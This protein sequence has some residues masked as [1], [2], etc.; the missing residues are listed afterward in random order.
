LLDAQQ[1]QI[2]TVEAH[3]IG[4]M[5]MMVSAAI[6]RDSTALARLITTDTKVLDPSTLQQ[7]PVNPTGDRRPTELGYFEIVTGGLSDRL[8]EYHTYYAF[9]DESLA[10]VYAIGQHSGLQTSW[11]HTS[12]GWNIASIVILRPD[13][14]RHAID[15]RI[16][17]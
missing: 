17:R 3:L 4:R 12:S 7:R 11:R 15:R 8:G 1:S 10:T 2:D 9:P 14:V 6:G 16:G 5:R 13:D